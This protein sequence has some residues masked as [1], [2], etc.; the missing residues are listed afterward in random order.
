MKRGFRFKFL[1]L[2]L[3]IVM[4]IILLGLL[5][6]AFCPRPELKSLTS[7]STAFFDRS[8]SLLKLT[9][10]SDQ[11]YR[12]YQNIDNLSTEFVQATLLYEDKNYYQHFGVDFSALLRAFWSTYI[13][14]SRRIGASTISMQVAR[15]RWNINSSNISGKF[16]QILRA[17]Q[18]SRHYSKR[19]ILEA[20]FNL[21]PYGGNIEGIGAASLIYFNKLPS[22]LSL[23]EA[24]TLAVIPQNPNKRNPANESGYQ[25]LLTARA[26]LFKRWVESFSADLNK[27][28]YLELTLSVRSPSNLPKLAPHFTQYLDNKRARWSHGIVKTTLDRHQQ[29]KL[30]QVIEDYISSKSHL[31]IKNASA[32]LLNYKTME[33]EAMVG[34]ADFN[35]EQLLGQ[36]NG[37]TAKR[38][39]GSTLKPFVYGLA[40]DEGLIHPMTLLKDSPKRYAGFSPENYDKK[41]VG[42]IMVKDA[43]IQS[44]NLPAV[45]LQS[46]LKKQSFYHFLKSA[47]VKGLKEE[48]FYGLALALGGG[49]VT[50]MELVRLYS[51]LANNGILRSIVTYKNDTDLTLLNDMHIKQEKK[52]LSAEASFLIMDMLKDNPPPDAL[53]I[54]VDYLQKNEIAWKTG[55]SWA[56]RD[57][58]AV[59]ISGNYVMAV[60]IGNFNG[61]GNS[62]FIGG[63]AAGP[64]LFSAF[65]AILTNERWTIKNEF[66]PENLNLKQVKVCATTGDLFEKY[67]PASELTWFIPGVSPIKVS[68]IYRQVSIDKLT[69][70]RACHNKPSETESKVYEFWPSDFLHL[71]NQAGISLKTPPPYSSDCS[72][73]KKS[74]SGQMPIIT[75]PQSSISYVIQSDSPTNRQILF[76]AIVD[77][78]VQETYWFVNGK[79]EGSVKRGEAFIWQATSGKFSVSVVDDFGRAANKDITVL[80]IQ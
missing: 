60:W 38:S 20:Y 26:N 72:L 3:L 41:F 22:Q 33:I 54:A 51:A 39:P 69:G 78:D 71:F 43:L 30:E 52:I 70:L 29:N 1:R 61:K 13:S 48:E 57:A 27:K 10:A 64:L 49:E 24:L 16:S 21:A 28:K 23:P 37:T 65:D 59:G 19:E 66:L 68:N 36:V 47:G 42:P 40:I 67:C 62:A 9:L 75:S 18:L 44:R 56:F 80:Q 32:L 7:Y 63:S 55:T 5:F 74:S 45:E 35:N 58:W 17:V 2:V 14:G 77:S 76:T 15:L 8:G 79:Y 6:Y 53:N 34:S 25:K 11:R 73:N 46:Q 31:G 4:L 50:M 12:L